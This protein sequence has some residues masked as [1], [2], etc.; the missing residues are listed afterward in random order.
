MLIVFDITNRCNLKCTYCYHNLLSNKNILEF[1][2][3]SVK[4][5][6]NIIKNIIK[7]TN[8]PINITFTGGEPFLRA[9]D[10]LCTLDKLKLYKDRI[11]YISIITNGTLLT[12]S[13]SQALFKIW[14]SLYL[15]ISLD[16]PEKIHN[17]QRQ[18]KN[19]NYSSVL[20][21]IESAR[22]AGLNVSLS[23]VITKLHLQYTA[24]E[25]YNFMQSFDLP[26]YA[27][28]ITSEIDSSIYNISDSEFTDFAIELINEWAMDPTDK[29]VAW[30]DGILEIITTRQQKV[31]DNKCADITTVFAGDKGYAWPCS[32][33]VPLKKYV[34]G[35]IADGIPFIL[36]SPIRKEISDL[37][38]DDNTCAHESLIRKGIITPLPEFALERER[39]FA[40]LAQH[41]SIHK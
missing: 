37:F 15:D 18:S 11:S 34:L 21:G 26:W 17:Y 3:I 12:Y 38:Y 19:G 30:I 10:L 22:K 1:D 32:R 31:K 28:K 6:L 36:N 24:L 33:L 2:E 35:S 8:E 41:V 7:D 39:L 27:G 9:D 13:L 4:S 16:G 29:S 5:I 23:S 20:L 14:P 25:Y 40:H